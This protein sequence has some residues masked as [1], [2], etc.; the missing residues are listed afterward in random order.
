MRSITTSTTVNINPLTELVTSKVVASSQPLS[1]FTTTEIAAIQT[2]VETNAQSIDLSSATTVSE[3]KDTLYT[4]DVA[5]NLDAKIVESGAPNTADSLSF[6]YAYAQ[7]YHYYVTGEGRTAKVTS[8]LRARIQ[9]GSGN[10]ISGATITVT[11]PDG[12]SVALTGFSVAAGDSQYVYG[13]DIDDVTFQTGTY[14]FNASF[15]GKT[16]STTF[17]LTSN[18]DPGVQFGAF[19]VTS[20]SISQTSGKYYANSDEDITMSWN[21]SSGTC[22]SY[23]LWLDVSHSD[24]ADQ[25]QFLKSNITTTSYS[26]PANSLRKGTSYDIMVNCVDNTGGVI[27]HFDAMSWYVNYE[28]MTLGEDLIIRP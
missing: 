27:E 23:T 25:T 22:S 9:D 15:G 4:G 16:A 12:T 19:S 7:V 6:A 8:V 20:T 5:A 26:I 17:N 21:I 18:A 10:D 11:K 2:Q 28:P 13:H 14:T 3:A 1:N 24:A